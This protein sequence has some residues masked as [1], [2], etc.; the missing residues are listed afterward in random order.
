[1]ETLLKDSIAVW[2][3]ALVVGI[4]VGIYI[5]N[6]ASN[7]IGSAIEDVNNYEETTNEVEIVEIEDEE[8]D[9]ISLAKKDIEVF[10]EQWTEYKGAQSGE[11][12]IKLIKEL[13]E[14]TEINIDNEDKLVD[15]EYEA[16]R[17]NK[18][19]IVTSKKKNN[20]DLFDTAADSIEIGNTYYVSVKYSEVTNYIEKVIVTYDQ[21]IYGQ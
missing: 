12:I 18:F 13:K 6:S 4:S 3:A 7:S 5:F 9:Y 1:M 10:N 11:E 16:T 2:G 17:G 8:D 15:L 21:P 19:T 20:K 14:N